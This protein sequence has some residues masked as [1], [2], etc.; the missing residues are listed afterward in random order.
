MHK[1]MTCT[2]HGT[3]VSKSYFTALL[4]DVSRSMER[5]DWQPSRLHGAVEAVGKL[6]EA[7][8]C[9]HP[10]D[11]VGVFAFSDVVRIISPLKAVTDG[12]GRQ[13]GLNA[14][15]ITTGPSTNITA[16]LLLAGGALLGSRTSEEGED[17]ERDGEDD[18][19]SERV[20]QIILLTDGEHNDGPD[21]VAC[22][23]RLKGAG[24]L[25]DV[26]GIGTPSELN[27]TSLREMS[28]PRANGS[29]SYCF[30]GDKHGLIVKMRQMAE[31][32]GC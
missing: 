31:H 3:S 28:S 15:R 7:R 26:I 14:G 22:A 32:S 5:G 16:G 24:V 29:P 25:I 4:L 21:P 9:Q 13:F 30:I 8:A 6:M 17:S 2:R 12:A 19:G 20:D 18:A 11:H 23:R 10:Q 1:Y 27:E